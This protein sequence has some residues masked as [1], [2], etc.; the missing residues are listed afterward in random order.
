MTKTEIKA[1][2]LGYKNGT[3]GGAMKNLMVAQ[4]K[5]LSEID[6]NSISE[7]IGK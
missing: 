7:R 2:M 5:S 4:S 3:Y 1:A 6:I